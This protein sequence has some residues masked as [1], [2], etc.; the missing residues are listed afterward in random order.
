MIFSDTDSEYEKQQ[1]IKGKELLSYLNEIDQH[2]KVEQAV[3]NE[4]EGKE[5]AKLPSEKPLEK[6]AE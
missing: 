2:L 5:V 3:L 1:D 4:L 6:V